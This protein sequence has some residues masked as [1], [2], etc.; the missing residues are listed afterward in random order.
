MHDSKFRSV[1]FHLKLAHEEWRPWFSLAAILFL[2]ASFKN[3]LFYT[4][5]LTC[6]FYHNPRSLKDDSYCFDCNDVYNVL[7]M[8]SHSVYMS[9]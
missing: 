9:V 1:A 7:Q 3:A 8:T 5:K 2:C 4:N 6:F